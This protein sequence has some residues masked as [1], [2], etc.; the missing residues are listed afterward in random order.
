M[1][2]SGNC[3]S[4]H[5]SIYSFHF[6]IKKS[7]SGLVSLL[8]DI[9][10]TFLQ[11]GFTQSI[12]WPYGAQ[13]QNPVYWHK[14]EKRRPWLKFVVIFENPYIV[15]VHFYLFIKIYSLKNINFMFSSSIKTMI[16]RQF[17]ITFIN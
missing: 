6:L 11:T 7:L 5:P 4:Y 3:K 15:D 8:L 16:M 2:F 12:I 13:R 1:T 17:T 9:I 10:H 14:A